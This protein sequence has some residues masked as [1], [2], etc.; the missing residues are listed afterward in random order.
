M[1]YFPQTLI[2]NSIFCFYPHLN[3]KS[4]MLNQG[5]IL[6]KIEYYCFQVRWLICNQ[7]FQRYWSQLYSFFYLLQYPRYWLVLFQQS[8]LGF[9]LLFHF[10]YLIFLD[11]INYFQ[12]TKFFCYYLVP[13]YF[14]YLNLFSMNFILNLFSLHLIKR[15]QFHLLYFRLSLQMV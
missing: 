12:P 13:I 6:I 10:V 4:E 1:L 5:Q 2:S 8:Y 14:Q 15:L 9:H 11:Y 7:I 3:L